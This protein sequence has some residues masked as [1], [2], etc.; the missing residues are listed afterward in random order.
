ML[1]AAGCA[2]C[3]APADRVVPVEVPV[4]VY[5]EP[6]EVPRPALPTAGL[7]HD[8]DVFVVT[9]ALWAELDVRDAYEARL[10]DALDQCRKKTAAP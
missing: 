9:R 5:C 8:A 10:L 3:A 7:R 4:P 6:R 1:L 2:G